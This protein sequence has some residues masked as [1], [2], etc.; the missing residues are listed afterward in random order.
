[1]RE[2]T[3]RRRR[4]VAAQVKRRVEMMVRLGRS[5]S[6]IRG[7]VEAEVWGAELKRDGVPLGEGEKEELEQAMNV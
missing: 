7:E 6:F 3:L 2:Y 5:P 1:M 4:R